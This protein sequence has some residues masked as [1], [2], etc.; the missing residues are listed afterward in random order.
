MKYQ[1]KIIITIFLVSFVVGTIFFIE[2]TIFKEKEDSIKLIINGEKKL[3]TKSS[4]ENINLDM[5]DVEKGISIE[6]KSKSV[7]FVGRKPLFP[8]FKI[9]IKLNDLSENKIIPVK[10]RYKSNKGNFVYKIN[11]IP[12]SFP[13]YEIKGKSKYE[14]DYYISILDEKNKG[15][16][17]KISN[18]GKILFYKKTNSESDCF[19]KILTDDNQTR[20]VYMNNYGD[21][22]RRKELRELVVLNEKY[23]Q[24]NKINFEYNGIQDIDEH[25]YIYINDNH[26]IIATNSYNK[27]IPYNEKINTSMVKTS[28]IKEIEKGKV[29]WV[30]DSS[31]YP[32]FYDYYTPINEYKDNPNNILD[33]MHFNSFFID[34]KDGNLLVSFRHINSVV[35]LDRK[36]GK[37]IWILGGKGDQFGMDETIKFE[38]QHSVSIE[39]DGTILLYDNGVDGR[40]SRIVEIKIDEQNKKILKYKKYE[41]D[42]VWTRSWGYV[43]EIDKKRGIYLIDYGTGGNPLRPNIEERNLK[44]GKVHFSIKFY[45]YNVV[46]VYK[47]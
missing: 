9:S 45:N 42:Q 16:L 22:L 26:Y 20:Y 41:L 15:Y 37:P 43:R 39:K 25:D 32:E 7:V 44:N 10:I 5:I 3:L 19:R 28:V 27:S 46:N 35:K 24:I 13:K 4:D 40:Q 36:T 21:K 33:Y 2:W 38:R 23:K 12:T 34:P 18:K 47:G 11:E 1:K 31:E 8:N 30:F 6:N 29:K 17:M 14:G